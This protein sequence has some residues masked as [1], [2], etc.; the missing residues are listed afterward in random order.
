M[1]LTG[2]VVCIGA[3]L[4]VLVVHCLSRY[5]CKCSYGTNTN[6]CTTCLRDL[7]LN[8]V[9][10]LNFCTVMSLMCLFS[11]LSSSDFGSSYVCTSFSALL[12]VFVIAAAMAIPNLIILR[13]DKMNKLVRIL[14]LLL[15]WS[16]LSTCGF[17]LNLNVF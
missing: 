1:F 17:S 4:V 10:L 12:H 16:E 6:R 8:L 9:P 14:F 3:L 15:N 2:P 7:R 13:L 11:A 5:A